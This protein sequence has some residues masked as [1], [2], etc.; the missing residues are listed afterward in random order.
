VTFNDGEAMVA[1]AVDGLGLAFTFLDRV[2]EELATGRLVRVLA[3]WSVSFPGYQLYHPSRRQVPKPLA[4]LIE[5]LRSRGR[6][7]SSLASG[8]P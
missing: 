8:K 2:Q 6:K 5:R 1:A 3:D 4:A 7:L